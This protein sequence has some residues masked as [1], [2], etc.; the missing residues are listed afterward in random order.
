[1][2]NYDQIEIVPIYESSLILMNIICGCLI[3]SEYEL[4]EWQQLLSLLACSLICIFGVFQIMKK[5][6]SYV[7]TESTLNENIFPDD[8]C[9][10]Q[11]KNC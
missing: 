7:S 5:P 3:L 8:L 1:M 10:V 2:E 9:A 6:K 11:N 4:Y